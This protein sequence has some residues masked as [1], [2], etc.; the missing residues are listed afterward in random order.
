VPPADRGRLAK[1]V[2]TARDKAGDP[3]S[4]ENLRAVLNTLSK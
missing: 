3:P 4:A 1:L 2:A